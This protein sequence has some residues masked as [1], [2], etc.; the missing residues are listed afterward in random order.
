MIAVRNEIIKELHKAASDQKR[1]LSAFNDDS[2]LFSFGLDSLS[3]VMLVDRLKAR[4]GTDLFATSEDTE[5][6]MT[7]GTLVRFY[8][9][10]NLEFAQRHH[11][12]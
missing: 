2:P 1:T 3:F 8:E 10:H 6:P 11:R 5:L 4:F 12:S 7:V 9:S